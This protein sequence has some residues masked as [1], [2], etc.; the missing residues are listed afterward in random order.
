MATAQRVVLPDRRVTHTVL[1]RDGLPVGP[2]EQYLEHLRAELV[3]ANTVRSYAWG[4][5]AWWT[6]LEHTPR[7]HGMTSP[8]SCSATS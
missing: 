3:P 2:V 6:V 4:L 8:A 5:A 1:G 7:G